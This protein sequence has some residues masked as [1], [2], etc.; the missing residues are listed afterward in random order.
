IR[1]LGPADLS[2]YKQ[3]RDQ[4][5]LRHPDAFTS[6]HETERARSPESYLG[7]LGLSDSL[8]GSFLLGAWDKEQLVGS[9]CL[10]R[11]TRQKT[12]HTAWLVGMMVAESHSRRGIG[13]ALVE[14]LIREARAAAGLQM[15]MLS[16]TASSERAVRLYESAGFKR[17]GL[18]P[19]AIRVVGAGGE[20]YY[21]KAF[22]LLQL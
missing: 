11:E 2:A 16:V 15:I 12:R 20:R 13:R 7:R 22:L 8:G 5:L 3:F 4:A 17:Y 6:D 19:R 21:D 18:L 1:R 9:V 10:E 14:Q